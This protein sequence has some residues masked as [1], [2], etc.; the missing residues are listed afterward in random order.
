MGKGTYDEIGSIQASARWFL[1]I[2]MCSQIVAIVAFILITVLLGQYQ[3]G[4]GWGV[5]FFFNHIK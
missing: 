3:G 4:F 5:S 1:S 2:A